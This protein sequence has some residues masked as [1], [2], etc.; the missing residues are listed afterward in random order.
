MLCIET[1][2]TY[3]KS[4]LR[5]R[6]WEQN[7]VWQLWPVRLVEQKLYIKAWCTKWHISSSAYVGI[8]RKTLV[9]VLK[10]TLLII[11]WHNLASFLGHL[12]LFLNLLLLFLRILYQRSI[13]MCFFQII[14]DACLQLENYD[15]Q[16]DIAM[17]QEP[18]WANL[19]ECCNLFATISAHAAFSDIFTLNAVGVMI[20]DLKHLFLIQVTN[21]T[22]IW[23]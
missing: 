7:S 2:I 12:T 21:W 10:D 4:W 3:K 15:E 22:L 8:L 11:V 9:L 14:L 1:W 17:V 19:R 16:T 13:A 6:E 20:E 5:N 23:L 18:A